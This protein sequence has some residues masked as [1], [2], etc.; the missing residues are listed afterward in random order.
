MRRKGVQ[1]QQQ[2]NNK[3]QTQKNIPSTEVLTVLAETTSAVGFEQAA[4]EV[5]VVTNPTS[6]GFH[7]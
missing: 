4:V 5:V 1:H 3:K 6:E 7:A 2:N